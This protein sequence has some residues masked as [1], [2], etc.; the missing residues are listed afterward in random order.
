MSAAALPLPKARR[1]SPTGRMRAWFENRLPAA[2]SCTLTQR[3]V[4]ILPTKGGWAFACMLVLMLLGAINYQLNL[5]YLLTFLLAGSAL[6]SMHMTHANLR[7]LTLR[8]RPPAPVFAGEA[9]ALEVVITNPGGLRHGIGLA[10][11]DRSRFGRSRAWLDVPALGQ[12]AA[13]LAMVPPT[14]GWHGL[15]A[16]MAETRFP[17][18]LFRAWTVWRPAARVLA[19]PKPETPPAPLPGSS[20]AQGDAPEVRRHEGSE[21]EGVRAWRRGDTLRQVLWKKVART[22]ELISRDTSTTVSRELWLEWA[23]AQP[24]S[25]GVEERLSRLAAWVLVADRA[26]TAY[27]LRLPGREMAPGQ[28]EVHRREL[29]EVLALWA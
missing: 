23:A 12:Q 25:G 10:F 18:G 3:N 1:L 29:L 9:A 4:Y 24:P 16:V 17:F 28:G 11:H 13:Q 19:Y 22:G 21:L 26:G 15:P 6:A 8:L 27:G 20:H 7:G 2:D 5:G 14:R